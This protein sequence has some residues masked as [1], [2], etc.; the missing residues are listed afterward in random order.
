MAQKSEKTGPNS[1][2]GSAEGLPVWA[3]ATVKDGSVE[4]ALAYNAGL[5]QLVG[6]DNE[7]NVLTTFLTDP[8]QTGETD[9]FHWV[10]LTGVAGSGKSRLAFDFA[11]H[12]LPKG[13]VAAPLDDVSLQEIS[14]DSWTPT[15][16]TLLVVDGPEAMVQLVR[17]F[18]LSLAARTET[19]PHPVRILL[20]ERSTKGS[21]YETLMGPEA[22]YALETY[23]F[24][25]DVFPNGWPLDP[26]MPAATCALMAERFE[27]AGQPMPDQNQMLEAAYRADPRFTQLASGQTVAV[28]RALFSGALAELAAQGKGTS[29][30]VPP[31]PFAGLSRADVLSLLPGWT[32]DTAS[33]EG[34]EDGPRTPEAAF[35]DMKGLLKALIDDGAHKDLSSLDVKLDHA[36]ALGTAFAQDQQVMIALARFLS[37]AYQQL[38]QHNPEGRETRMIAVATLLM[39]PAVLTASVEDAQFPTALRVLKTALADHAGLE[40]GEG[41]KLLMTQAGLDWET[42]PRLTSTGA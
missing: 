16:P 32:D 14:G 19:L 10:C 12:H 24:R 6:R 9:L 37:L 36:R 25:P 34:I 2:S 33:P 38:H 29:L 23:R 35:E 27:R 28:P 4:A 42:V 8:K 41:L 1:A 40:M 15:A 20:L 22:P 31:N 39:T 11:C 3:T 30:S 21:W 18:M 17:P 7:I 26:L 13:W 5:Y